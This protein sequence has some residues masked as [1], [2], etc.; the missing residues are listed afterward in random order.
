METSWLNSLN[1]ADGTNNQVGK[2]GNAT[3][4]VGPQGQVDALTDMYKVLCDNYNCLGA[5]YWEPAWIP[6]KPGQHYWKENKETSEKFGNGWA[7]RAAEGYAPDSKMFYNG[8]PTAG[9]SGWDNMSLF[10]FN[11]YML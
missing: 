7:A 11:G 1:D 6:T 3:Y 2:T 10:D 4:K 5:Y 8:Q 9:A